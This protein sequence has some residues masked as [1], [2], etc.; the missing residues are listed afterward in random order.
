MGNDVMFIETDN[1]KSVAFF[2]YPAG[3]HDNVQYHFFCGKVLFSV[4]IFR[5]ESLEQHF[6]WLYDGEVKELVNSSEKLS[7]S[8]VDYLNVKSARLEILVKKTEGCV[9]VYSSS[10]T[11][12][13]IQFKVKDS[14]TYLPAKQTEPVT[15]Q[16][17]LDCKVFYQGQILEGMGYCKRYYGEYPN[18]WEYRFIHGTIPPFTV[19]AADAVFG[20]TKYNYFHLLPKNRRLVSALNEDSYVKDNVAHGLIFGVE[21]KVFFEIIASMTI[22]LHSNV[23]DSLLQQH[24]CKAILSYKNET[25]VGWCLN[26]VCFGSLG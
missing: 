18:S 19:W 11:I 1:E 24:Y 9:L 5:T 3:K 4:R 13:K 17:N 22:H 7:Q 21:Y 2:C 15:H 14:F 16:P 6:V 8:H 12:L 20:K 23:M 10:K 25:R 26:E